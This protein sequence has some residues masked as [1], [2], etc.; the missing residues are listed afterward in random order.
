MKKLVICMLTLFITFTAFGQDIAGQWNGILKVQSTQLRLVVNIDPSDSG[1]TATLD[2]PDQGAKDIQVTQTSFENS[3]LKFEVATLGVSYAGTLNNEGVIKGTFTQMGQSLPLDLSK[4]VIEKEAMVRPQEPKPPYPYNSEE[5]SF[6]NTKDS[7]VLSGTLTLPFKTGKHPV[8]VMITG[9]G[10]QNRDEEIVGH[11]PFFVIADHLTKKGIGVL[12]F[13]DRGTAKSTGDFNSATTKDFSTDVLSAVTYLK[14]RDD[15]DVNNIGL[16]GHSEGG[17]IAPMVA[18]QSKDIAFIT[19]LAGPGI[20][21]YDILLQQTELI[22]KVNGS[23]ASKLQTE[24]A[25]LKGGL[26]RI[27]EGTNLEDIKSEVSAYMQ[28]G[29]QQHPELMPE[30]INHDTYVKGVVDQMVTPWF[31]Y[32]L[33]YDPATSLVNVDCPVLAINGEKDLQVPSKVNL[34]AI[35]KYLGEGGNTNVVVKELP[36]LNHLFQ[37]CNTGSPTEYAQIEQTFAPSALEEISNWI[38]DTIK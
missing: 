2:S 21:G 16:V 24:L 13:D 36:N 6:A 31:R 27:I 33:K 29:L 22:G 23:D 19:L 5:V 4:E 9:S 25:L 15:I 20:S 35:E 10:P 17:L 34:D 1:Y 18:S 28:K 37:E 7:I 12:R 14:T 32:F 30:G 3:E 11:K 26:D 8:V 38:L